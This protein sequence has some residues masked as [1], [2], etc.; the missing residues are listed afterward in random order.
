MTSSIVHAGSFFISLSA[1]TLL[2]APKKVWLP[3]LCAG[4]ALT[5]LVFLID[6]YII[7]KA[8]HK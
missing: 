6:S 1:V 5:L 8:G 4:L 3:V 7:R 2:L